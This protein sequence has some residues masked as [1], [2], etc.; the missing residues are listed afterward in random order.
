MNYKITHTTLYDY[1][2]TVNH[3]INIANMTPVNS[4]NQQC[5]SSQLEVKPRPDVMKSSKDYFGN[6]LTYFS[7]ENPHT[8]LEIV[9][10]SVVTVNPAQNYADSKP[11]LSCADVLNIMQSSTNQDV[12]VTREFTLSSPLIK[13]NK[14]L[15]T[16]LIEYAE[17]IFSP[18]KSFLSAVDEFNRKIFKEFEFDPNFST[19]NTPLKEVF[20][21]RKG[22]CQDFSHFAIAC[23][24]AMGFAVKYVSG[25]IE[26]LPPPGQK[27]LVGSDA[28]HA[29]FSVYVPEQGWFDF[30]PTNNKATG[31]QHIVTAYGRDY[32]DI[33]PLKGMVFGS[34]EKGPKL[35]VSVDVERLIDLD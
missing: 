25:Y 1:S 4:E 26:T 6:K 19:L 13:L 35:T 12:I 22:V 27:K 15:R 30:D 8:T 5:H 9:A 16:N 17:P 33:S 18:E 11:D 2:S 24:R 10:K 20:K 29:W 28:S 14:K 3:T 21:Q 32:S 23:L 34:G 31:E 7:V